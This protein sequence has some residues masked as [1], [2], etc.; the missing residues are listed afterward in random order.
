MELKFVYL[1]VI[2]QGYKSVAHFLIQTR[3]SPKN[4][5]SSSAEVL[6]ER[7]MPMADSFL[8]EESGKI[9]MD[10]DGSSTVLDG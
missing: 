6:A 3:R 10:P 5:E 4:S 1:Q 8:H 7:P 2:R 9:G